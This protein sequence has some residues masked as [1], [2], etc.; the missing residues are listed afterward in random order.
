MDVDE[1]DAGIV[2]L[3]TAKPRI[4][5]LEASRLLGV[6]RATVQAR[7][8]RMLKNQVISSWGPRV[9][10]AKFGFPV[11]A[12]CSLTIRQDNGHE[13]IAAALSEIPEVLEVHTVSGGSDLLARVVARSNADLQR[14]LD[15]MIATKTVMR[16]SSVMVLNT[17]FE[18]RMLPLFEAAARAPVASD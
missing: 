6:A 7:L 14:V 13:A 1:L 8:D 12:F 11:V 9:D 18:A 10:P 15:A 2:R 4:S 5:V 16:S 3:F 17:H